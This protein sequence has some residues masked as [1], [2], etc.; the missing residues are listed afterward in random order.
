M[1]LT[2]QI[3]QIVN[4]G[5]KHHKPLIIIINK[6]DLITDKKILQAELKSRLKS[7]RYSPII[8]LSALK[9]IGIGSLMKTL[10]KMLEQA[11]QKA[12]KKA[13]TE[14]IEKMLLNNP[15]KYHQGNKL[16]IYFAKHEPGL[17]HYFILFVNNPQWTHFSYQRYIV[18]Y[19]RKGLNLEYLPI[20]VIL[21]KSE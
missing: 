18:N 6:C 13:L 7:L 2:K 8:Y 16:K 19:L 3:L 4:L 17:V 1:P 10:E 14:L 11:H 21:K 9:G 15:P 20:K 5:E 12:S